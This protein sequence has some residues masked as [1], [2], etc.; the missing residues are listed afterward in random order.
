RLPA[1]ALLER[2]EPLAWALAALAR[3]GALGRA[4]LKLE[5]LRKIAEAPVGEAERFL[6]TNC[7]ETYLQLSGRDVEEFSSLRRALHEPEVEVMQTTWADRMEAEAYERAYER[8]YAKACETVSEEANRAGVDRVRSTVLR[9][10]GQRFG[11]VPS[12]LRK[13]LE[14]MHSL[15]ELAAI[16]DRILEV[17]SVGELN[18]GS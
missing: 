10:L 6:L 2:P 17:Q 18:L 14:A 5:L 4:R 16:A 1:E 11:K 8:A 12:K 7:V 15:D 3:P 9:Q 13:R